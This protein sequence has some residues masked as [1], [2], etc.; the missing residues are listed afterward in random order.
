M[1]DA[2]MDE[3]VPNAHV[4]CRA[5]TALMMEEAVRAGIGVGHLAAFGTGRSD[6]FVRLRPPDASLNLGIWLLTHRDLRR[7]ARVRSFIDFLAEELREQRDLIEGRSSAVQRTRPL[8][9]RSTK[10]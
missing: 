9:S 10:E 2:W 4:V 3:H 1:T 6:D 8:R 5:N 7:S